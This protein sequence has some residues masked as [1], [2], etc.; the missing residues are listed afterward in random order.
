VLHQFSLAGEISDD[1]VKLPVGTRAKRLPQALV[2]LIGEQSP[3]VDGTPE[4]RRGPLAIRIRRPLLATLKHL[5]TVPRQT[6]R[7]AC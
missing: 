1:R 3:L 6:V 7:S 2:V 5:R 4:L